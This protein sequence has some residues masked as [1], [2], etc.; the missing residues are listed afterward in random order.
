[1]LRQGARRIDPIGR[2]IGGL[3]PVPRTVPKLSRL[4]FEL[5]WAHVT[6]RGVSALGIVE[7]LNVVEHIDFGCVPRSIH[8]ARY[9]FSLERREEVL[10]GR[11][12]PA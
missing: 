2:E 8:F 10:H 4:P 11:V 3:H 9:P 5:H 7:A 12:V 1:M 6:D